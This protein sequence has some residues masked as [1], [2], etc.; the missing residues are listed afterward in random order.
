MSWV[1]VDRHS[2]INAKEKG[3]NAVACCI[4]AS[5]TWTWVNYHYKTGQLA[6]CDRYYI[7]AGK[8]MARSA[9]IT[10]LGTYHLLKPEQV[11]DLRSMLDTILSKDRLTLKAGTSEKSFINSS[12][13][14][15]R[16]IVTDP[17]TSK[18]SRP[19]IIC[20]DGGKIIE[21]AKADSNLSDT[22]YVKFSLTQPRT[23]KSEQN[24]TLLSVTHS[25]MNL[26][27]RKCHTRDRYY[28][29]YRKNTIP[30]EWKAEW[31]TIEL[32]VRKAQMKL[33][34]LATKTGN[35]KNKDVMK[36]QRNLVLNKDFRML[37]VH[38]VSTNKGSKTWGIDRA[39]LKSDADK[40]KTV[41]WM[42]EVIQNPS[43]YE[44]KPVRRVYIPKAKGKRR[45]LGIPTLN[46]RCLQ[47]LFNL[48]IEPLVEMTSDRHSYGF[49]KFRSTKMA[50]GALRVNLRSA[51][52]YYD[53]YAL[54]ADIKG[55]FDNISHEWLL[56]NIPL[57]VTLKPI[58]QGWLK[59]GYVH[60]EEWIS[61]TDSGTP[62]GG[63]ISPTLANFTLNG[64]EG[65]VEKAVQVAYNVKKR[66]IY[67]GKPSNQE[68]KALWG[69]VSTNLFTVRFADDFIILARSKRMIEDVIKP[70]VESFLKERGLWLSEEKTKIISIREGEKLDFL[71]YTFQYITKVLPKYKLFHD[72]QGKEAITTYPQKDKYKKVSEKLRKIFEKSYNL[73]SYSLIAEINPIVRGWAQ[74]FNLAQS[75][76]TRNKLNYLL[77]KMAWKWA[78][79]KHPRWGRIKIARRYFL[80]PI[81]KTKN[82][83][84]NAKTGNTN[85]WVFKGF[86]YNESIFNESKGGKSIELVNP[87][88]VVATMSPKRYRIPKELEQVHAFHPE[89]EKLIDF[90]TKLS[91]KSL[92][93][94]KT[95]KIKLLIKQRGKCD[96]CGGSLLSE[97]NEFNYDGSSQ[98]HHKEERSK[99]GKRGSMA[100]L[101]LVHSSCHINHHNP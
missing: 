34:E 29:T 98:I 15:K 56:D 78:E 19:E 45:P 82:L 30:K 96:M 81:E 11:A 31:K 39:L 61:A 87:T 21:K 55:F 53:K 59:V 89:F 26:C 65:A 93:L 57:E 25:H 12:G 9:Y 60:K 47:A 90:N 18:P 97:A 1:L 91:I 37:A 46:D 40:W 67:I 50:L 70:C 73:S 63:I 38:E 28:S 77:Y 80:N 94:N 2:F 49:R 74:Y 101:S 42:K 66:G 58:L 52:G 75:Y 68:R 17:I 10:S 64:M 8:K 100:N 3:M 62:Q 5:K 7:H 71:G 13:H 16:W 72:R 43:I 84:R 76:G 79:H 14:L 4:H 22:G 48:V 32:K 69:Y 33:V 24:S 51:E 41:E 54:D 36:L 44:A 23:L 86:T 6:T 88:Q 35:T 27:T 85:K 20:R 83:W 92:E 99:G 95:T